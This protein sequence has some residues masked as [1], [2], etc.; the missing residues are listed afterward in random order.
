MTRI[1]RPWAS[2]LPLSCV[3]K[4]RRLIAP[5]KP[6]PRVNP[7]DEPANTREPWFAGHLRE[8]LLELKKGDLVCTRPFRAKLAVGPC[9]WVM[10][11]QKGH[12]YRVA[13]SY[14]GARC[15]QLVSYITNGGIILESPQDQIARLEHFLNCLRKQHATANLKVDTKLI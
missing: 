2:P 7:Q 15:G 6:P 13:E 9:W 12:L 5:K 3:G 10:S 11:T 14:G 4:P 8:N 1:I